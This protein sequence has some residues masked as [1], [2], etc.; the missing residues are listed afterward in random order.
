MMKILVEIARKTTRMMKI[1]PYRT[2]SFGTKMCRSGRLDLLEITTTVTGRW[3][4]GRT[5]QIRLLYQT[6]IRMKA[7]QYDL[8]NHA[9]LF[10]PHVIPVDRGP[11]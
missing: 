3:M 4:R 1:T 2:S 6:M 5:V 10:R 7:G 11:L 9:V 8:A